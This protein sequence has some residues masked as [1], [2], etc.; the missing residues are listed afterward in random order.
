VKPRTFRY[1]VIEGLRGISRHR[2]MAVTAVVT[3]T[4]SLLVLG[5]FLVTS[6]N[7]RKVIAD[8]EARKEVAVYL[9][10]GASPEVRKMIE[11]RLLMHPAVAAAQFVSKDEA[12]DDFSRSMKTDGLL[13]MVGGNPLPDGFR[14][15]LKPEGRDAATILA[16]AGEAAGWDEVAE[17]VSGGEWVGRLDR[18]AR[19][20]LLFTAAIGIAVGLSII[21]IVANTVRLTVLARQDLIHIMKCV[22]ASETFIRLPFLSEGVLQALLSGVAAMVLLYGG[23][24][25]VSDRVAGVSFLSPPWCAGFLLVSLLLG[26][27]GSALSVRHV[28]RHVGL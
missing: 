19:S 27:L 8:L 15:M 13:E 14:V 17:V 3:M 1:L 25:L 18:F 21:L 7:V 5:A 22:G 16:L 4:A 20:A 2:A 26:L 24:L 10:E 6:Y 9:E 11:D 23:V 12:W 28:L